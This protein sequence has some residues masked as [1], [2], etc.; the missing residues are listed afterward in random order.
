M[1]GLFCSSIGRKLL[2]S[3]SGLFLVAFLLVHLSLNALLL[4]PDGGEFFNAG[5]HD[6]LGAH[7]LHRITHSLTDHRLAHTA[8]GAF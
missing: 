6:K 7:N 1:S 2:M 4:V 5:A 8:T 3:L